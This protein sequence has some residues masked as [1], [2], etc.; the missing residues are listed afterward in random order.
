M[1]RA[2]LYM[3]LALVVVFGVSVIAA[4]VI[5]LLALMGSVGACGGDTRLV[6]VS[7]SL[8]TQ[9]QDKWDAFNDSLEA[10]QPATVVFNESEV[11]SRGTT[12]LEEKD[13]PIS[14]LKV[15][16]NPGEG[17]ATAKIDV[18]FFGD[19]DVMVRGTV[20]L[21]GSTP[22]VDI[23]DIQVGGVPDFIADRI[24]GQIRS[25]I[26]DQLD[27]LDIEHRYDLQIGAGQASISGQ[28]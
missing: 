3:V 10:G 24:K 16:L 11:T 2:F 7:P 15:C 9:F 28:P 19:V 27:D 5:A 14:G 26:N 25:V 4:V 20:D 18:P 22:K 6:E 8:A 12:F 1:I 21:S 23:R 13:A 17:E